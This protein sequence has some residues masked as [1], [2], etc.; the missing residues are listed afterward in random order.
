MVFDNPVITLGNDTSLL[1]GTTLELSPGND[2]RLYDWSTGE[3]GTGITVGHPG[4]YGVEV[5]DSNGCTG[6]AIITVFMELYVPRFFTPNGDTYNDT[7]EIEYFRTN[8]G[9]KIEIYDRFGNRMISYRGI[10][11]GWDGTYEGIPVRADSYWYVISFDDGSPT[12]TG[13][14]TIVR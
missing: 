7:W 1:P 2:F 14:V 3:T 10:D 9:A 5:T 6:S 11:R 4:E 12:L 8:P 13:Y